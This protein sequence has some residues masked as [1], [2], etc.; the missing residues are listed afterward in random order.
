MRGAS[1]FRPI[2]LHLA[3]QHPT[4]IVFHCTA[5]KDRTGMVS[6]LLMCLAGC[7]VSTVAYEY[8]L[9]D[10]DS[11]GAWGASVSQRLA[12]QPGL[13]NNV[14]SVTN[15]VRARAEYMAATVEVLR[16]DFGGVEQYLKDLVCLDATTIASVKANLIDTSCIPLHCN[17]DTP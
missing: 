1:A 17:G 10:M 13:R 5:G 2:F 15:V 6:M 9:N 14:Q 8:A 11:N 3:Q 7:N 4:P 16:K 12:V